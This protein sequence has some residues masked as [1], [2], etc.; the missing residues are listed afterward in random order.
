MRKR[1]LIMMITSVLLLTL[2]GLVMAQEEAGTEAAPQTIK[3]DVVGE[4]GSLVSVSH[5][6]IIQIVSFLIFMYLL[7]K[8]AITPI[9]DY[10]HQRAEHVIQEIHS[11]EEK[12]KR[13][14]RSMQ[15]AGEQ[16]E[17][18]KREAYDIIQRSKDDA[19]RS[20]EEIIE[21]AKKNG[22]QMIES[23][24]D[25]I[26]RERNKAIEEIRSQVTDI[27]LQM[28]EQILE[29]KVNADDDR[30][31]LDDVVKNSGRLV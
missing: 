10:M 14:E 6:M 27:A 30:Q 3:T 18:A 16:M 29:R 15:E 25:E 5:V 9:R 11:A 13:A 24:R 20:K 23:A 28:T 12:H 8:F 2:P 4:T 31:F 7:G 21:E 19:R 22:Q 26:Q 1:L 17:Q